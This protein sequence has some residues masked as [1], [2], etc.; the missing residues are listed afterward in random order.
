MAD[1]DFPL[2]TSGETL[3]EIMRKLNGWA[4]ALASF[5]GGSTTNYIDMFYPVGSI[6]HTTASVDLSTIMS[7]T[8]W[9]AWGQGR[10]V[11]GVDTTEPMFNTS[12]KIGGN[13]DES[14]D[15]DIPG[16]TGDT[17]EHVLTV[18]EIPAHEHEIAYPDISP[19][20]ASGSDVGVPYGTMV[21]TTQATGGSL[22]HIHQ[23]NIPPDI[24]NVS[25]PVVQ[26]YIT[27]YMWKRIS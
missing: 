27:C 26:P 12:E 20:A 11:V 8:S 24:R 25:V 4:T 15:V 16:F 21:S 3:S 6:F 10:T 19:N 7:G 14:F 9:L 22:G 1:T 13:L 2:I 23:F 18:D 17:D 5:T